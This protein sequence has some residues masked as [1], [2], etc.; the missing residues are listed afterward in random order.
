MPI[1]TTF[2]RIFL[3]SP[4]D[5]KEERATVKK[6]VDEINLGNYAINGIKLELIAWETH[7][8]PSIGVDA[9]DVINEQ[10][11]DNYDIFIGIMWSRFGSPTVRS[12]SGTKEEFERA[13]DRHKA[14]SDQVKVLFY[15]KTAPISLKDIDLDGLTKIKGFQSQLS[16]QGVYY[17]EF[18]QVDEFEQLLRLNLI[19]VLKSFET[20][21]PA[22][23][24]VKQEHLQ[25]TVSTNSNIEKPDVEEP[26][27]ENIGYLEALDITLKESLVLQ[28]ILAKMTNHLDTLG[29]QITKKTERIYLTA[30]LDE[31]SRKRELKK[32]VDELANNMF[33]YNKKT[34]DELP[35]LD[36]QQKLL[37]K[38]YYIVLRLHN[39]LTD[40]TA[41]KELLLGHL[42][43][44]KENT[45]SVSGHM[46]SM[47]ESIFKTP[48]MTTSY[49]MAKR[50][51]IKVLDDIIDEFTTDVNLLEEVERSIQRDL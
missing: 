11:A 27:I 34:R 2:Y 17:K 39:T 33:S 15:F 48:Q 31:S 14:N 47:R 25:A 13:F 6:V 8:Y 3:A 45:I 41:E 40:D 21:L 44:L 5:V 38:Y 19:S 51:T 28:G 50:E 12:E 16:S 37:I 43:T 35:K 7:T 24:N 18:N 46:I 10:I 4:S 29:K 1:T 23:V 20:S 42:T 9:Q 30:G 32:I 22:I 36:K 26:N 49:T